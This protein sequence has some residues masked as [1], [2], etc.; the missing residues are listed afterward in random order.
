MR[1]RA[2]IDTGPIVAI[3]N[4]RDSF[5]QECVEQMQSLRAPLL[6]CWPV[7]TEAAWLLRKRPDCVAKLLRAFELGVFE[8]LELGSDS[9]QPIGAILKRYE[10][11]EPQIADAAVVH[12]ARRERIDVIF[13]LDRRDFS[14]Y[15][16]ASDQPFTLKPD[17]L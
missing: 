12:L 14:I 6:T 17:R 7:L 15:R 10:D 16:S 5:H 4:Q 2:L 9:V 13:T 8:L 1:P 3:F 11:I